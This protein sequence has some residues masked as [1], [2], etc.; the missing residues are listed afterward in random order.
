MKSPVHT[1]R[2]PSFSLFH[3]LILAATMNACSFVGDRSH[4]SFLKTYPGPLRADSEV[5]FIENYHDIG[6][7]EIEKI[8]D[9]YGKIIFSADEAF[10]PKENCSWTKMHSP[11][12]YVIEVLPGNYTIFSSKMDA[13]YV[14]GDKP[15]DHKEF[16]CERISADD[17]QSYKYVIRKIPLVGRSEYVDG[18]KHYP[19]TTKITVQIL[20]ERGMYYWLGERREGSR[21]N[22]HFT[23]RGL[24]SFY[25]DRKDLN[26]C[27]RNKLLNERTP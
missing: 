17:G 21:T 3:V 19:K 23:W 25:D 22:D 18:G 13:G 12:P 14:C 10:F 20:A 8:V 11:T 4:Y 2:K 27:V 16:R 6:P 5:A 7:S 15:F 1:K 26:C 9:E 24:M